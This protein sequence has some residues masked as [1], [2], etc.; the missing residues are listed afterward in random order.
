MLSWAS[1][2]SN[3]AG[4][5]ALWSAMSMHTIYTKLVS[6]IIDS[7]QKHKR[8]FLE[9]RPCFSR[10]KDLKLHEWSIRTY[11]EFV[12]KISAKTFL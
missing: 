8:I 5:I 10:N 9:P 7:N 2:G 1:D 6:W 12:G 11:N 3:S 4:I